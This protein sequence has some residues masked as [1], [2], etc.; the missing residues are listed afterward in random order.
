[1][2]HE[3]DETY[4]QVDDG[5]WRRDLGVVSSDCGVFASSIEFDLASGDPD[6]WTYMVDYRVCNRCDER[7][8]VMLAMKFPLEE[9]NEERG[10]PF[11]Y[12][13]WLVLSDEDG[14]RYPAG[15]EM[16][17]NPHGAREQ[18]PYIWEFALEPGESESAA[19][20]WQRELSD[21]FFR[22]CPCIDNG[23][24]MKTLAGAELWWG[25]LHEPDQPP[26]LED[27]TSLRAVC[28]E[29]G[30]YTAHTFEE[31]HMW[32]HLVDRDAAFKV[33]RLDDFELPARV[34][35]HLEELQQQALEE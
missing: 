15:C 1:M 28:R 18:G 27:A 34:Q 20:V 19:P 12:G 30:F 13:P 3:T 6:E 33:Q 17:R 5:V 10:I 31:R 14:R 26:E 11:F 21:M 29:C 32:P 22:P 35:A 9:V 24:D 4:E 2:A 16:L 23:F 7:R 25:K 8:K